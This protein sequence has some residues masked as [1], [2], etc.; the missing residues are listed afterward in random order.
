MVLIIVRHVR[1]ITKKND[2]L[3]L[4]EGNTFGI[5]GSFVAPEKKFRTNFCLS[6]HYNGDNS[7]LFANGKEICRFKANNGG[8]NFPSQFCWGSISNKFSY[9]EA[10][11]VSLK[12]NVYDFSIDYGSIAADDILDIYKYLIQKNDIV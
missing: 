2:F 5:N 11:E 12:G 3:I 10:E 4:G 1:L 9:T 6:L 8:V 7:Y